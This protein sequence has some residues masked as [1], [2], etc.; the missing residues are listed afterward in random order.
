MV[1]ATAADP[2][3]R[4][5]RVEFFANG[6][7]IGSLTAAP[8]SVTWP[9]VA[10]GTYSLTAVATDADG[11][12]ATSAPVTIDVQPATN[13]PPIVALTS[14]ATGTTFTAPATISLSATASDPENQLARGGVL[15]Q[16]DAHQ[17]R[18][19]R[20]V[21]GDVVVRARGHVLADGGGDRRRRQSDDVG[22]C[23]DHGERCVNGSDARRVQCFGRSRHAGHEL[24]VRRV[25]E[26]RQTPRRR[27]PLRHPISAS[28]RRTHRATSRWIARHS[29]ARL[30][31]ARTWQRP[32]PLAT[33]GHWPERAPV[34]FVR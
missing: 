6:T 1:S 25:R 28:R 19:D 10:T 4:L 13:Q 33:A 31:R 2:E 30:R 20:S 7:R 8:F 12:S 32:A 21:H 5:S 26:R 22:G 11:G 34:T 29:S 18:H 16:R 9:N 24:S 17:Q 15:S 3:N 23:R 27:H 14:P